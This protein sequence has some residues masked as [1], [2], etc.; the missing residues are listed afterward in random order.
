[1]AIYLLDASVFIDALN[2]EARAL[3]AARIVG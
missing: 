1:M 2:Q 3:G